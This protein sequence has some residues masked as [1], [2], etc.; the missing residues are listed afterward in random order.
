M[1]TQKIANS[2]GEEGND[3]LKFETKKMLCY[4]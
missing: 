4:Q 2:L 3:S 1:E